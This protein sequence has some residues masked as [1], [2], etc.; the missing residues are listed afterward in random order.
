MSEIDVSVPGPLPL[1]RSVKT[2]LEYVA[3]LVDRENGVKNGKTALYWHLVGVCS[4][5]AVVRASVSEG[6]NA[7]R[8]AEAACRHIADLIGRDEVGGGVKDALA[9]ILAWAERV[10]IIEE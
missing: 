6:Y 2:A 7:R 4:S 8:N 5:H 3:F 9:D 1:S 10:H